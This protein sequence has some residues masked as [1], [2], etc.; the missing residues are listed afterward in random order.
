MAPRS[1]KKLSIAVSGTIPGYKQA[2]VKSLV[3]AQGATFSATVDDGCTHL[4]TTERDA[5]KRGTK[6]QQ[7][8]NVKNCK[9]VTVQWLV[10][11]SEA[12]KVLPEKAYILPDSNGGDIKA[13]VPM[14]DGTTDNTRKRTI[15]QEDDDQAE[16]NKKPKDSQRTSLKSSLKVPIDNMFIYHSPF[17]N[18]KD[19]V[20][21]IEDSGLIWD[22]ALN[23]TDSGKNNNKFYLVQLIVSS[24][25]KEYVTWTRWGRVGEFGQYSTW[26]HGSLETAKAAFEK[27]FK[28]KSG[29]KWENR[30]GTPKNGKY[31]FIE[32]NYED[33]DADETLEKN[34]SDDVP[35]KGESTLTKPLQNLMSFIFNPQHV[36]SALASMSYDAK[37]LPLGKLSDRTLKSGFLILKELAELI[38]ETTRDTNWQ[39][40]IESLSNRYFTTIPHDFRRNRPPILNSDQLIKKEVE[41]LDALTDMDVANEIMKDSKLSDINELDRQF[42]SLGMKEM[43][44]LG[45]N[46]SEYHELASYLN[47]SRGASHNMEYQIID[48]FRI[49]RQGE[50]DRFTS[51]PFSKLKNSDRRLLWHGS[52]STNFGGIL[53]QG[54]RIAPPEAPVN[55]YMFGKGVYLA[56]T[57]TKSANYCCSHNSANMGL[58]LLCD[59]ELG[60]PMLELVHSDSNAGNNAKSQGKIATLGR[61]KT[62]PG[63]WKDAACL[64]PELNGV[65]MP[66]VA[67]GQAWDDNASLRY[68][69]Y[70]VYDVAQIRQRYLFYVHMR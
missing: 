28:D 30:L 70:I 19:S 52:R 38:A 32:R 16:S 63:G 2:D 10:A 4:I 9:I 59:A 18:K 60:D 20:V 37:K 36:Q 53:S 54:L 14:L 15:K 25:K 58:L 29:L 57:S 62:V 1:F 65:T 40:T 64:T 27:K 31:T 67:V 55:G 45:H 69:E 46:T 39:T 44:R 24:D 21:L 11:S 42:Q 26:G 48:I 35:I 47:D 33:D 23:Q 56:D 13:E 5:A 41:L 61:G 17:Q 66:D 22:A 6:Y 3:E 7:A 51:S 68:N 8:C 12:K 49:E 34:K 43:T 50:N